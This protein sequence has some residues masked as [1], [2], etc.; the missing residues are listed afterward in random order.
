MDD[1][2]PG[3]TSTFH[4]TMRLRFRNAKSKESCTDAGDPCCKR[5][6]EGGKCRRALARVRHGQHFCRDAKMR[7]ATDETHLCAT[8]RSHLAAGC[9]CCSPAG[10]SGELGASMMSHAVGAQSSPVR[11]QCLN[12]VIV[13]F[14]RWSMCF[15]P[16]ARPHTHTPHTPSRHAASLLPA[17]GQGQGG[18][19]L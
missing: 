4:K 14:L 3:R 7:F 13:C 19:S 11:A 6:T 8:C 2:L 5:P 17:R 16:R 1:Y 18:C 10:W 12:F 9:G 15:G